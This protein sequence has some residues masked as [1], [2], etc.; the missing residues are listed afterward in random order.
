M[1]SIKCYLCNQPEA[2]YTT[3]SICLWHYAL[4]KPYLGV[5]QELIKDNKFKQCYVCKDMAI[6]KEH[7]ISYLPQIVM[8]VCTSC[9]NKIHRGSLKQFLPNR[10]MQLIFYASKGSIITRTKSGWK[11]RP[12]TDFEK[13]LRKQM[14]KLPKELLQ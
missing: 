4:E 3:H 1:A 6:T 8:N 5:M 2:R 12:L 10:R 13:E 14:K 9:H 7:H 11:Y